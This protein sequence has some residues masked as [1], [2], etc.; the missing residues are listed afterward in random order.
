MTCRSGSRRLVQSCLRWG[1]EEARAAVPAECLK[2]PTGQRQRIAPP[3]LMADDVWRQVQAA[4]DAA[5]LHLG[6]IV[7]LVGHYGHRPESLAKLCAE[8]VQYGAQPKITLTV[9][10]GDRI[11]HPIAEETAE[12]LRADPPPFRDYLTDLPYPSGWDISVRYRSR[13]GR[14]VCPDTPGIYALKRRAIS[15]M[16][17]RGLD[18][19]TVASI[20]GHRRPDVLIRHYA[21]TNEDRQRRALVA[22]FAPPLNP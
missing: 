2:L 1:V 17:A 20:T 7:H 14:A 9:K 4:A 11:T 18:A 16:L 10:G 15:A 22:I 12:R 21:R 8:D 19:A 3:D 13:V 6:T 5:D